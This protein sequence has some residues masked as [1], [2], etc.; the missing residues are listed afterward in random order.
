GSTPPGSRSSELMNIQGMILMRY[1]AATD[2]FVLV[3]PTTP[4]KNMGKKGHKKAQNAH[5]EFLKRH[6]ME[7]RRHGDTET[8]RRGD[9]ETRRHGDSETRRL[10]DS[11]TRGLGD[12]ETRRHGDS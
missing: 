8:R 1:Q 10:G 7:T 4:G 3:S 6:D 2:S 12:T 9:T 11:E 5:K